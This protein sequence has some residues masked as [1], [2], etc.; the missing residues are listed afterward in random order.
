MNLAIASCSNFE[1]GY[2]NAYEQISR[3]DSLDAV[4]FMGDYIYELERGRYGQG[5]ASRQNMPANELV[6][7]EDYRTRYA[8][9]RT[10]YQLQ[11]A[12]KWQP[13]ILVWDDHEI[14]NNAWKTGGQNHQEETQ[15]NYQARKENAIQAFYEWM[16]VRKP[17]G[18]LLY[19]SFSIG[20]LVNIIMLDTRL[21]GRQEQIYNIDSP[22][23]YLPNRT[24][25]GET[26]LAWFKEQLSKPF[27]WR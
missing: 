17:Q 6:T 19:R 9:Y 4:L 22:N 2:F 10:D 23:V 16:P 25:L 14:V 11:L 15:G 5:F 3:L 18:H 20:S 1:G 24:M 26:Q 7:L 8:Q 13:F 27:K 12:H 21:E